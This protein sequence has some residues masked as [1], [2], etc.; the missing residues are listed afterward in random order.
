MVDNFFG[1]QGYFTSVFYGEPIL[2]GEYNNL[3]YGIRNHIFTKNEINNFI[4]IEKEKFYDCIT[5][6]ETL[7]SLLQLLEN[8]LEY[9]TN[10]NYFPEL[11]RI[12]PSL[13]S[14]SICGVQP[15]CS[16]N[17]IAFKLRIVKSNEKY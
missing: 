10:E 14:H 13:I 6:C 5:Y 12:H 1:V 15:M 17:V 7:E 11:K 8:K 4:K 2:S 9:I 3:V 16:P